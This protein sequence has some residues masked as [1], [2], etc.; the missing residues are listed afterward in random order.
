MMSTVI[1]VVNLTERPGAWPAQLEDARIRA[2]D[3]AELGREVLREL[4]AET[5]RASLVWPHLPDDDDS[6]STIAR[7]AI[8]AQVQLPTD[9]GVRPEHGQWRLHLDRIERFDRLE[10]FF[11]PPWVISWT[12]DARP[13]IVAAWRIDVTN[14][15]D[16]PIDQ[17]VELVL[18]IPT[19]ATAG[20]FRAIMFDLFSQAW[21]EVAVASEADGL[22]VRLRGP[23]LLLIAAVEPVETVLDP[24]LT[25]LMFSGANGTLL[26]EFAT[27]LD[28]FVQGVWVRGDEVWLYHA[29]D[30]SALELRTGEIIWIVRPSDMDPM[31]ALLPAPL[32]SVQVAS[33]PES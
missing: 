21:S 32:V 18:R 14:W 22:Q 3:D 26:S 4:A 19:P 8:A 20:P 30:S 5:L 31:T 2:T 13:K 12:S 33:E 29:T 28:P 27:M 6:R 10:E 11:R 1:P 23:A 15:R 7:G 24:G 9:P 25:E 17:A 16:T